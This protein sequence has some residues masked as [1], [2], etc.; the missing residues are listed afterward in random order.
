MAL[1]CVARKIKAALGNH[2]GL[3]PEKTIVGLGSKFNSNAV[4]TGLS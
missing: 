3:A 4:A 1:Q 2:T